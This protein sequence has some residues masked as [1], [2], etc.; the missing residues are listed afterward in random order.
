MMTHVASMSSLKAGAMATQAWTELP[1]QMNLCRLW[2]LFM[3]G[4]KL[5]QLAYFMA[6]S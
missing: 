2:A 1:S 6:R 5:N 4:S 3:H